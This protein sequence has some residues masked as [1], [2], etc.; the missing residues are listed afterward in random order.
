MLFKNRF[1]LLA[2]LLTVG[3]L[4]TSIAQQNKSKRPS[5]ATEATATIDGV[6]VAIHYSS[7][8]VK[9][10]TIWGDLVPYGK[11]WR[12]GANEAT[13]FTISQDVEIEGKK[14]TAGKYS[15]FTIP[16][17]KEWVFIFNKDSN[18][19]GSY[20]YDAGKDA[21]RVTV[22]PSKAPDFTE[23]LIFQM[24]EQTGNVTFHWADLTVGFKVKKA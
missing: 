9:G 7:P 15:L 23:R 24:D 16:G 13:T 14:L 21:L 4:N 5:P 1:L 11:V 20:N 19:W 17:E 6:D 2:L 12:T 22:Q 18:Q 3:F 8:A 10:R